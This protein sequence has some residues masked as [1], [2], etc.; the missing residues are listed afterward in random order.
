MTID[1]ETWIIEVGDAIIQKLHR[2][3]SSSLTSIEWAIY[4]MWEIDYAVR[5]SG[6]FGPLMDSGSTAFHDLQ[7][8]ATNARLLGL[9]SWLESSADELAFCESY[10]RKFDDVCGEL[11]EAYDNFEATR[12]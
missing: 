7:L 10:Y 12:T 6:C 3:G 11:R 9:A 8:F 2:E 1:L 5:N 4:W